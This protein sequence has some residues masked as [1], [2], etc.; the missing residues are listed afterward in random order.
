VFFL[1]FMKL[2]LPGPG[3]KP[4]SFRVAGRRC[5]CILSHLTQLINLD[6]HLNLQLLS[7]IGM[8]SQT[9]SFHEMHKSILVATHLFFSNCFL[10]FIYPEK[11]IPILDLRGS[12][13]RRK[14]ATIVGTSLAYFEASIG[15]TK[16]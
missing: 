9:I 2:I 8:D 1:I 13:F 16:T 15:S 7:Y 4:V 3:F 10:W 11:L 12:I 5:P 14:E 6:D